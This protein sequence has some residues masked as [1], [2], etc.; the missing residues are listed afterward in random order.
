MS[1]PVFHAGERQEIMTNYRFSWLR[2]RWPRRAYAVLTLP[3]AVVLALFAA[4]R[5]ASALVL[6]HMRDGWSA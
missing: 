5:G 6:Q 2:H 4:L 1:V 3:L